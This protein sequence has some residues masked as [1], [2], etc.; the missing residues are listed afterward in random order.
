MTYA[1]FTFGC[2]VDGGEVAYFTARNE[3]EAAQLAARDHYANE[4]AD[5]YRVVVVNE[6]KARHEYIINRHIEFHGSLIHVTS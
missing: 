3:Y 4:P 5:S 2:I 1:Q 6:Q